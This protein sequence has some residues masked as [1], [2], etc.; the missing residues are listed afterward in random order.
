M[1]HVYR[2]HRVAL[3]W[4]FDRINLE[5]KI[6]IK[7]VDTKNQLADIPTKGSFSRNEWN[8][9]LCLF[10]IMNFS[11]CSGSHL[12]SFLSEVGERIVFG[13]MSNRGQDTTSSDSSSVA[14]ARPTNLVMHGQCKEDT[15][16]QSSGS[17]VNPGNDDER[18]RVCLA[19]GNWGSSN[20]N[21]ESGNSQGY[22]QERVIHAA[23]KL[24]QKDQTRAKSEENSLHKGTSC[25]H[26]HQ[27][28]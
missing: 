7:Y 13:A 8:H 16:P 12:T 15:S 23:R 28:W 14:K 6:Q 11:T 20:S 26:H 18:I 24:G 21:F 27:K 17:L 25:M 3:D 22:R 2:T 9:L 5:P 4:L 1:R 19:A 10:N